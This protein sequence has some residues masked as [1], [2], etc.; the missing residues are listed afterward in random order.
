[1]G[2]TVAVRYSFRRSA[3]RIILEGLIPTVDVESPVFDDG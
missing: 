2:L 1:M 3:V